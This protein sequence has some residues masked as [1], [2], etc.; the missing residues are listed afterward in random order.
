MIMF[1]KSDF[2]W[3]VQS[4]AAL[5]SSSA[6]GSSPQRLRRLC[7]SGSAGGGSTTPKPSVCTADEL[8]YV[9]LANNE[10]KLAL[11]RYLPSPVVF[12]DGIKLYIRF[13]RIFYAYP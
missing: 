3:A 13:Y 8:H 10:W 9:P 11:W 4:A 1:P 12:F 6:V 5:P 2:R 7:V